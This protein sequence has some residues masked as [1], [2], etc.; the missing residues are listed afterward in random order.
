MLKGWRSTEQRGSQAVLKVLVPETVD[1]RRRTS[2]CFVRT[3]TIASRWVAGRVKCCMDQCVPVSA[4]QR[5]PGCLQN[6]R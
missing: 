1:T 2:A 5:R 3:L 6:G 4:P